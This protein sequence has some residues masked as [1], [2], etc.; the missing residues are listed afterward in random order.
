MTRKLIPFILCLLITSCD[1]DAKNQ[2]I[3]TPNE[4]EKILT[5]MTDD[6]LK[7]YA[8]TFAQKTIICDGH[9]DLPYRM[10]VAGFM[11]K[12]EI[13]DVSQRTEGNFDYPKSVEGGLDAPFMSIYIPS[14]YQ[15]T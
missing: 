6:E 7:A 8:V 13:M 3:E 1:Q 15:Q 11:L 4:T 10:K 14:S 2:P 9:V 5:E 12:K